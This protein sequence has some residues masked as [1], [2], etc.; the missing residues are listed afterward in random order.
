MENIQVS[1]FSIGRCMF[2]EAISTLNVDNNGMRYGKRDG[3]ASWGGLERLKMRLGF[4][5]SSYS[6]E[7]ELVVDF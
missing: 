6:A 7:E 3:K 2:H 4:V 1:Y 5:N